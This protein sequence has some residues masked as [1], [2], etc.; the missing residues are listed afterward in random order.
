MPFVRRH[1]GPGIS[2][3][4]HMVSA[5]G[6]T[7]LD[8]VI[9]EAV[10]KSIRMDEPLALPPALSEVEVVD[11][12]R[13]IAAKNRPMVQMIGMGYYDTF[14][15]AVIQRRVLENPGWY[16]AYTP[17]QPEISQ[18]RL[19]ALLNFQ[20]MVEDLT[21]L[22]TANASLLDEATAAAEAM[23]MAIRASRQAHVVVV[24][25]D[26]FPQTL[27]VLQT[28]A[29]PLGIEVVV[30]DLEAEGLPAGEFSG[31]VLQYP[32]GS[33]V[34]RDPEPWIAAAHE[35]GA[36]AIVV[37]D[38]LALTIL[39]PPGE[40]GA[41][42]VVG[43]SQR[44]GV[45][46]GFG[47]PHAGYIAVREGLERQLPGRLVGVSVDADGSPAYRL[48]LQTREQHIRREKATSNIC[49]AQVL[50]AV[51]ASMYAVYHGPRGLRRIAERVLGLQRLLARGLGHLGYELAT[52]SVF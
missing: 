2:Q 51:M 24:D 6:R 48:A 14:T 16:T 41:D 40:M 11:E 18:G 49:T 37:A 36:Q 31:L 17:Y 23:T 28:R 13:A 34:V 32:A 52:T 5:L 3:T 4:E 25:A 20:T 43:S 45:P 12:L 1:V 7:S 50:L 15:P 47:G 39:K 30:R 42:I 19:E 22:P 46:L 44:F 9:D 27:A 10:P 35:R 29:R 21:A 33:G 26:V 38:L 8:A